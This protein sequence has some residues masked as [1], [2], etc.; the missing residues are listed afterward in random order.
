MR[1]LA[2]E[3]C[4]FALPGVTAARAHRP[5]CSRVVDALADGST[6][7]WRTRSPQAPPGSSRISRASF[8]ASIEPLERAEELFRDRCTGLSLGALDGA[9]LP[10]LLAVGARPPARVDGAARSAGHRGARARRSL[11]ADQA[12]HHRRLP[13]SRSPRI[14]PSEARRSVREALARWNVPD[15]IHMQHFNALIAEVCIDLYSGDAGAGV[16]AARRDRSL[17]P[18]RLDARPDGARQFALVARRRR[19]RVA[20]ASDRS[21]SPSPSATRAGCRAKASAGP[22]QPPLFCARRSPACAGNATRRSSCSPTRSRCSRTAAWRRSWRRCAGCAA[23]SSAATPASSSSPKRRR[24]LHRRRRAQSRPLR[25]VLRPGFLGAG[26]S[27]AT[28]CRRR[29]AASTARCGSTSRCP[30]TAA[31]RR[32]SSRPGPPRSCRDRPPPSR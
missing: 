16:D 10:P 15:E 4:F 25:R 24:L 7:R 13:M 21:C 29:P 11:R 5:R 28:E 18:R 26:F 30:G 14:A 8:R 6:R 2:A 31:R 27:P 17:S 3:A 19:G 1:A 23:R 22:R 32:R 12:R 9:D 20:R